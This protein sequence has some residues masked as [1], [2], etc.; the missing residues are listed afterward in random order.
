MNFLAIEFVSRCKE[1]DDTV[2]SKADKV[3]V[4]QLNEKIKLLENFKSN[5]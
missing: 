3:M 1:I 5:L 4:S 2:N